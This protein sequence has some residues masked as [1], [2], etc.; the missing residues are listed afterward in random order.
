MTENTGAALDESL[1]LVRRRPPLVE[2]VEIEGEAVVWN[3]EQ[4]A[5]HRLDRTATLVFQLCD[6]TA[7]LAQTAADLADAFGQPVTSVH[8]DVVRCATTLAEAGLVEV[9]P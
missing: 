5:L 1:V 7:S 8:A 4:D 6:G 9:A 3:A 2:W